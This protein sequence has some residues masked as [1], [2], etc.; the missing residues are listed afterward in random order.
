MRVDLLTSPGEAGAV[1]ASAGGC[2]G[3]EP[4]KH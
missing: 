1:P 3:R 4:L 2:D